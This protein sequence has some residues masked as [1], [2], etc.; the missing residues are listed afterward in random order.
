MDIE[1]LEKIIKARRS[2]RQWK[3]DPVPDAMLRKAV[4]IATW[5]PNGGN[6]QA[7]HFVVVKNQELISKMAD[8]VQATADLAASWPEAEPAREEMNRSQKNASYFRNAP[9]CVA[10][11]MDKYQSPMDAVL[12]TRARSGSLKT[13]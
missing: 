10:V 8:A 5:A 4:E 7:W 3:K 2:V 6:F 9:A 13:S 11:F 1:G 12:S